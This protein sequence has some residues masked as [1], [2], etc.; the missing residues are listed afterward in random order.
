MQDVGL[1]SL[2]AVDPDFYT[3]ELMPGAAGDWSQQE[4][5]RFGL[6]H[7]ELGHR[8]LGTWEAGT[9]SPRRCATI[10]VRLPT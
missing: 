7:A 1:S 10:I 5:Q 9:C 4:M 8:L 6:D 2:V 3:Q